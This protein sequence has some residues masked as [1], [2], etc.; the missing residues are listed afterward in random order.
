MSLVLP[1]IIASL[2]YIVATVMQARSVISN[3]EQGIWVRT[4]GGI[5]VLLHGFTV[6]R[7]LI[8]GTGFDLGLYP[9]LS[10]I[11]LSIVAIVMISSLRRPV[12][13][14]FIVIFPLATLTLILELSL[15]GPTIATNDLPM[16]TVGHI[17]LSIV[18][19]GLLSIAAAQA[20]LLSLGDNLLRNHRLA[21][22]RNMPPLETMEQLMFE[23]VTWGLVFLTLSITSGFITL[24]DI[25]GPGLWHHTIITLL[26]WAVFI[27][28][29]WGRMQ[30]G[31][32][33]AIA[34]RW[35]L[36]GFV[37]LALGYIG[38]KVVLEIILQ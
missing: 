5:A 20:A 15:E 2:C 1:G 18:A 22:L 37:L 25:S 16:G 29:L 10:L 7:D 34:S 33:G 30:L 13:N 26:A 24:E 11:T 23:M 4:L 38:S 35:A 19:F 28:L 9:M 31:W 14:L 3:A 6:L 36:S 17:L 8:G 21:V 27:V 32:R 12:D